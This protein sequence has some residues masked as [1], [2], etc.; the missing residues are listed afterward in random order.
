MKG[1]LEILNDLKP[2]LIPKRVP[3]AF[4]ENKEGII[5]ASQLD[6]LSRQ[7]K[8][9]KIQKKKDEKSNEPAF[10]NMNQTQEMIDN[11]N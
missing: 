11:K 5:D 4:D 6:I 3:L 8:K 10:E 2:K 1:R 7:V 9:N